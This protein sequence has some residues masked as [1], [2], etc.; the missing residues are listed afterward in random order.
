MAE[1]WNITTL[2][3]ALTTV[4]CDDTTNKEKI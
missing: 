4:L 2:L 1:T 3:P